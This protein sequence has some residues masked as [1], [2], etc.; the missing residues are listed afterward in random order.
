VK[1]GVH[2]FALDDKG[3]FVMFEKDVKV[4]EGN[5]YASGALK[6][7]WLPKHAKFIEQL[8]NEGFKLRY[9]GSFVAD[10]HQYLKYGG[11][12]SYPAYKGKEGGKLRLL[13]EC[14]PMGFIV[15]QAGGRVSTG[16][17]NI[18]DIVPQK[19]DHR[20]PIYVGSKG[21]VERLE[22]AFKEA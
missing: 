1:E 4:P 21:V 10:V 14:N 18:L 2:F 11:I 7:E 20:V 8:E 5:L 9:S 12:F 6:K 19:V 17:E 3:R 13:F 22:K 15:T 16:Y